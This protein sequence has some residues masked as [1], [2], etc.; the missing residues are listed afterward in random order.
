M[1]SDKKTD[2][3]LL[4]LWQQL[5]S[6]INQGQTAVGAS[7]ELRAIAELHRELSSRGY[8]PRAGSWVKNEKSEETESKAEN[9]GKGKEENGET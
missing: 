9:G 1:M 5:T 6:G 8:E 7:Q 4:E 3:E 2:A